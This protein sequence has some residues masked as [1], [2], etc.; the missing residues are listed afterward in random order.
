[1]DAWDHRGKTYWQS[2]PRGI[3]LDTW[4]EAA[5]CPWCYAPFGTPDATEAHLDAEHS[6]A[7]ACWY[8]D[9]RRRA[10]NERSG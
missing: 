3:D 1:M 6:H 4:I 9:R 7:R 8:A 10:F 5:A 2:H